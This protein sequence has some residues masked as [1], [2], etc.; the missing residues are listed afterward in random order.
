ME[1]VNII[2]VNYNS[3]GDLLHCIASVMK[4]DYKNFQL[5]AV[6]NHSTDDSLNRIE[7]GAEKLGI[8]MLRITARQL[9]EM[10][11][12]EALQGQL[13]L[14]ESEI[15]DGF[16]AG[17]NVA[18]RHLIKHRDQ[19]FVWLLNPDVEVD[20]S[21][22][23][24]LIE[25][26]GN[27]DKVLTGNVINYFNDR[28][29]V[30]YWGGFKVRK[31]IH[32]IRNITSREEEAKIDAIA[33]ASLF[34]NVDT[35][36]T[37]G[38]L[39]ENYFLYWEETDFCTKATRNG[40]NFNV[41]SKSKIYDRVGGASSGNFTREYLYILSG[42]RF[43]RKYYPA[44]L[45]SVVVSVFLKLMVSIFGT[46][47]KRRAIYFGLVD[48]FRLGLGRKVNIKARISQH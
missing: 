20:P 30:M 11:N 35:F 23:T 26:H 48:F 45:A 37:L 38:L 14:I 27:Q 24:H 19:E 36:R 41:N 8:S 46:R 9:Q 44:Y 16:A 42:L 15:N 33:G 32:G 28:K 5:F 21:V 39:P 22:M 12:E 47:L 31:F 7:E 10:K 34:T 29:Q 6:D 2:T 13:V 17:N 40:F 3:S 1:K 43:Y 18:L 4:S 25:V